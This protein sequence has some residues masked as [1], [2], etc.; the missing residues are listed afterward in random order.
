MKMRILSQLY[1][2]SCRLADSQVYLDV[3]L[4]E[5]RKEN[6]ERP[7]TDHVIDEDFVR[8]RAT[9]ALHNLL[10]NYHAFHVET[11][12]KFFQS[13]LRNLARELD[14]TPNLRVEIRDTEVVDDAVDRWID[15]LAESTEQ[16]GWV[17]DFIRH[18]MEDEKSWNVIGK[19]KAFGKVLLSDE[20]KSLSDDLNVAMESIDFKRFIDVLRYSVRDADR[21]LHE[22]GREMK[23]L[24]ERYGVNPDDLV[25]KQRGIGG[26]ILKMCDEKTKATELS[27]N[28]YVIDALDPDDTDAYGWV[29]KKGSPAIREVCRV[30]LKPAL[31]E[32]MKEVDAKRFVA[33]SAKVTL[34]N[35][36]A[37]RMLHA[38]EEE[39]WRE[40]RETNTFLL[41][42][43]QKLLQKMI[44]KSD[45][46]FIYE[47]TGVRLR[48]IMIDEFQDTSTIQW[49]NFKVLLDDSLSH[50]NDSLIVGDVKQ[51]IYRWRSGDWRLLND[52][53]SMFQPSQIN[54]ETLK[55]N[56][57]S[58]KNVIRF[59]NMFFRRAI[60]T[61]ENANELPQ[62]LAD[63]LTKAYG[64][65][66]QE[67][68]ENKS[69]EG[70]VEVRLMDAEEDTIEYV[71][72]TILML[73][74]KG[75][76][77]RD[78]AVLARTR[79][80]IEDIVCQ[81]MEEF[82]KDTREEVRQLRFISDE[83]YLLCSSK[84]VNILVNALR[85]LVN[86]E[87]RLAEASL[88]VL[89]SREVL[90]SDISQADI[91]TSLTLPDEFSSGREYLLRMPLYQMC[92]ELCTIFSLTEMEDQSAYL[93]TF[94]DALCEYTERNTA[95]AVS[96]LKHWD[97][98]M[99]RKKIECD[100]TDG[101]RILTIHKS[102]GL[103]YENVI[104]PF[105]DWQMEKETLIWSSTSHAPFSD[106]PA[107]PVTVRKKDITDTIFYD[108][109]IVEHTQNS[110][111]NINLL[112]V[113]FTRAVSNLFITAEKGQ[114][115]GYRGWL[116]ENI[117]D[118]LAKDL[119]IEKTDN[120]IAFGEILLRQREEKTTKNIFMQPSVP[121]SITVKTNSKDPEFRES[122]KS[123]AFA[124]NEEDEARL[125]H[126]QYIALGNILHN[127]F[128]NIHTTEDIE[129]AM[130]QMEMDGMLYGQDITAEMI[131]EKIER[132]M[133]EE[134]VRQWF[135]P[136]WRVFNECTILEYDSSTENYREHRPDRVITRQNETIVI[137]FKL[138]ALKESYDNQVL[139]YI[140]LLEKM[141]HKNVRGFLW[142]IMSGKIREVK[143]HGARE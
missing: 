83:A 102:K 62:G 126:E 118:S 68:P 74:E 108:D 52:I 100:A 115:E 57:R 53:E 127:L 140:T 19:I 36:S 67:Y 18:A 77:Q 33:R 133:R 8:R 40:N 107:I 119:N 44:G 136:G 90:R 109:Y 24:M 73:V 23:A 112:Y 114:K 139:R 4:P 64:D 61:I 54:V 85:L 113:G 31:I 37:L 103:E 10:H 142:S 13:V 124:I 34:D 12:D 20:Y 3:M 32:V 82:A 91:L 89:Y 72:E 6:E 79:Q 49:K 132:S 28:R 29:G 141:G 21:L 22:K 94:F 60:Q 106:L 7:F 129:P 88:A 2:I 14:L 63:M 59:N 125:E 93:S 48:N 39:I 84:A 46:P 70:Y 123:K 81:C 42:D 5:L 66:E 78:I 58:A 1:G 134:R 30:H 97:D 135:S 95:D 16:M 96:F 110:V 80:D 128:S 71:R 101:I 38:I 116:I 143:K 9:M 15:N 105:C 56:R 137:D 11:I 131:R 104:I 35:L 26:F 122:N 138:Y 98:A 45:S 50:G 87:D 99:S 43:T 69:D 120:G 75:V 121:K 86:G 65:V 41:S 27:Q 47:K 117:M 92:E 25:Q 111:D 55:T 51:S 17:T 76:A 130:L